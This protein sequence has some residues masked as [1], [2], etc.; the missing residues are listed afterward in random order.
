[1][2]KED[3][4]EIGFVAILHFTVT[5]AHIY[6]LGRCRHISISNVGTP[7]EMM[8]ICATSEQNEKDVTELICLHNWD[9]DGKLT[10]KKVV[11]LLNAIISSTK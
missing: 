5:N 2:T 8:W 10:K 1:M 11:T 4:I 6:H 7:N 9:Y 3:L